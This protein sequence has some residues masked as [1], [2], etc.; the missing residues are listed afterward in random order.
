MQATID[1]ITIRHE[2]DFNADTSYLGEY[3]YG[4]QDYER[5]EGL[6]NGDWCF[7]GIIAEATV[8]YPINNNGSYRLET[9]TSGGLWGIES[10][11]G[12][13]LDTVASEQI[14]DLKKHLAVFGIKWNDDI[15]ITYQNS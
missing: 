15:E 12:D 13:Y 3:T 8:K 7:I 5:M 1:S 14:A 11:S 6:N 10:D 4:M 9:F 2:S